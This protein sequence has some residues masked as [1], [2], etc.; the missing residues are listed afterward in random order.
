MKKNITSPLNSFKKNNSLLIQPVPSWNIE[1]LQSFLLDDQSTRELSIESFNEKERR[2]YN[3]MERFFSLEDEPR[4][5]RPRPN[6]P[7]FF[8]KAPSV[9]IGILSQYFSPDQ[10]KRISFSP[11]GPKNIEK[12]LIYIFDIK[13]LG[14]SLNQFI[15]IAIPNG[16]AS[17]CSAVIK[18][19]HQLIDLNFT[20][21]Q[22]TKIAAFHGGGKNISSV[23]K[24][25]EVLSLIG[26]ENACEIAAYHG[27]SIRIEKLDNFYQDLKRQ[28]L[29]V[30]EIKKRLVQSLN[31]SSSRFFSE[32]SLLQPVA[33]KKEIIANT[34]SLK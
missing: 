11:Y 13:K 12:A 2:L 34:Q 28:S 24:Y 30:E 33:D 27:A 9:N 18:N 25:Q 3:E 23:I 26:N 21:E 22:I 15:H 1:A 6:A 10:I 17:N 31:L 4:K 8:D 32:A 16:G 5:K 19:H 7:N 14:Y 20:H 29:S